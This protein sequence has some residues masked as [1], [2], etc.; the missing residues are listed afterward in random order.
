MRSTPFLAAALVAAALLAGCSRPDPLDAVAEEY[1]KLALAIGRH[2]GDYVDAYYGPKA[3]EDAARK[4]NPV[5]ANDLLGRARDLLARVRAEAP[6]D[7]RE[8]LEKQLVSVEAFLRRLSGEKLT[9][10]DEAR[11]LYDLVPPAPRQQEIDAAMARLGALLPGDGEL[12]ARLKAFRD[13]FTVPR[14]RVAKVADLCL[15]ELRRRTAAMVQLPAGESF[16]VSLVAGKPWGAYNWYQGNLSSLID[17]NTDLPLD[18]GS[19]LGTLAHE[20]YP[21][22]HTFNIL[23]EQKLVREK[24]WKEYT[25]SPLFSPNSVVSEGAA[26]AGIDLVMTEAERL[27]FVRDVLAPAAGLSGL[28]FEKADEVRKAMEPLRY[29]NGEAARMLLDEGKPESEVLAFLGRYG[30][31]DVARARKSIAFAKTSRAYEYTYTAGEDLVK[32]YIGTGPDR[33][34]RFFDILQRPVTPS[35]LRAAAPASSAGAR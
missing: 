34:K 10:A 13:K 14:D 8:F 30:L 21:G 24:G 1:V 6:S 28:D 27:A 26:N 20:G 33:T 2:D 3:W 11:L 35:M 29:V 12:A 22:H 7:R 32:A 5:P 16:H 19:L 25:V 15:A 18:V 4:G 23:L 31:E 17:V 9:M